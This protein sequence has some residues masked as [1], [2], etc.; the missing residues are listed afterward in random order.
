M[1]LEA[2]MLQDPEFNDSFIDLYILRDEF[3]KNDNISLLEF[4]QVALCILKF[5]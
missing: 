1:Y 2:D 4:T 3:S 5:Y